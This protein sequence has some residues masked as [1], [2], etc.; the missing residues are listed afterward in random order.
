VYIDEGNHHPGGMK[1]YVENRPIEDDSHL[2]TLVGVR[3]NL[4]GDCEKTVLA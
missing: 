4:D 2:I 1:V 3:V